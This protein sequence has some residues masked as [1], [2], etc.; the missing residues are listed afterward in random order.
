MLPLIAG[1]LFGEKEYSKL[2]GVFVSVNTAGY[3]LGPLVSN[4]CFDA[5]GTYKPVF[6]TYAGIMGLVTVAFL[7]VHK[8][9]KATQ[10]AVK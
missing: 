5:I 1:D 6:W 4:L 10:Q 3:A 7:F 2:L 8:Q 9:V